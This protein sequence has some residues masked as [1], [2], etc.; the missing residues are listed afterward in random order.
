MVPA[1]L[2]AGMSLYMWEGSDQSEP[3]AIG[4]P[5]EEIPYPRPY[6]DAHITKH[7]IES[8]PRFAAET[9]LDAE[10]TASAWFSLWLPSTQVERPESAPAEKGTW[11]WTPLLQITPEY[12]RTIISAARD[13]D[14][15]VI[16]LS[17]D[18]YLDIHAMPDGPAKETK[19]AAFDQ[20]L[21][22][23]IS[24][25]NAAGIAVDA[26]AGWRNWAEKGHTYKAFAVLEYAIEFNRTH[27]EQ[28]RGFQYDVEPYLLES[29]ETDKEEVLRNFLALINKSVTRLHMS[30]LEFSVAIP[31]FYDGAHGETPVFF[32]ALSKRSALGHLLRILERR[33]G[34]KVIVMSYRNFTEGDNG[35]IQ[36]SEDEI[37]EAN[38]YETKIVIAQET[39]DFPPPYITFYSHSRA[40]Y[41]EHLDEIEQA[42]AQEKSYGGVATHYINA[43]MELR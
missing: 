10:L 9:P 42:F 13:N 40:A 24:E 2:V 30:D 11:L 6:S 32:F 31:E 21:R 26:E 35:A 34:S 41:K 23:F 39:G 28:L 25:A 20:A 19:R 37:R 18:S 27:E 8:D 5:R 43:L 7:A 29:Y 38:K 16:Y 36:I 3:S 33:P 14:I 22:S 15:E 17:I 1:F 4:E 12:R